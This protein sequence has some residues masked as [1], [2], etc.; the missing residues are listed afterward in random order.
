MN[1]QNLNSRLIGGVMLLLGLLWVTDGAAALY[2]VVDFGGKRCR[3]P[4][5][6]S[7]QRAAGEKGSC[8]L[9]VETLVAPTGGS[10][11]CL[12]ESWRTEC[13]YQDRASCERLAVHRRTT[14][15]A[16]PNLIAPPGPLEG[17]TH[18]RN[19]F[20][21]DAPAA[22]DPSA[23]APATGIQTPPAWPD[24]GRFQTPASPP[25]AYDPGAANG[26]GYLPSPG[27]R[28]QPGF[29]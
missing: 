2:C 28:P 21:A 22:A 24:R 4:D 19:D 9:N 7:C 16:N 8:V 6:V 5:L 15:I 1:G 29:R 12:V 17:P 11:Y 25:G 10:P 13:V 14:C 27:Y 3:Y 20:S 26:S 18:L 23:Q